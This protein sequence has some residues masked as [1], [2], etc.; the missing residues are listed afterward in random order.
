MP[1]EMPLYRVNYFRARVIINVFT[2]V[3]RFKAYY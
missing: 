3:R 1:F 2:I